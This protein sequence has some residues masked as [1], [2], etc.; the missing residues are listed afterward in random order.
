MDEYPLDQ[1]AERD[2]AF[3]AVGVVLKHFMQGIDIPGECPDGV[4][5]GDHR[6]RPGVE[7]GKPLL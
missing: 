6:G 3:R 1:V 5:T 7:Q 2:A 4:R